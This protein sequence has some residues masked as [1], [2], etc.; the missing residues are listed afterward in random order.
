MVGRHGGDRVKFAE[1]LRECREKL[2]MSREELA[3]QMGVTAAAVGHWENRVCFPHIGRRQE[4]C[5][6][7]GT[8]PQYLH[9]PPF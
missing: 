7:L 9:L 2:G 3:D 1:R 6:I 4:L 5:N 8:T